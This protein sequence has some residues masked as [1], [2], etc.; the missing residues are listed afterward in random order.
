MPPIKQGENDGVYSSRIFFVITS[1]FGLQERSIAVYY[2]CRGAQLQ[3]QRLFK[4]PN[5]LKESPFSEMSRS[6][7]ILDERYRQ[8]AI[9]LDSV[10]PWG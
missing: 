8:E 4:Q 7:T 2:R 6:L 1:G 9:V 3:R 5:A 10:E